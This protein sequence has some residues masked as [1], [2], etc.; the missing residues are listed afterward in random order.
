MAVAASPCSWTLKLAGRHHQGSKGGSSA[1]SLLSFFCSSRTHS[2]QVPPH[3]VG[4]IFIRGRITDKDSPSSSSSSCPAVICYPSSR[5]VSYFPLSSSGSSP[6]APRPPP[7]RC[8]QLLRSL[9]RSFHIFLTSSA[10]CSCE[11]G[12]DDT[13]QEIHGTLLLHV[14]CART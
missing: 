6:A 3:F 14:Q 13:K 12:C 5:S 2:F 1:F 7:S 11:F 9:D 10:P 4:R 8:V